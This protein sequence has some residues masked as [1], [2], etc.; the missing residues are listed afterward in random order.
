MCAAV[1]VFFLRPTVSAQENNQQQ[2]IELTT[3]TLKPGTAVEFEGHAKKIIAAFKKEGNPDGRGFAG[4]QVVKGGTGGVYLFAS[5]FT[6]WAE[7]DVEDRFLPT[8]NKVYGEKEARKIMEGFTSTIAQTKN[9]MYRRMG[10]L[11]TTTIGQPLKA[12]AIIFARTVKTPMMGEYRRGMAKVKEANEKVGGAAPVTHMVSVVGTAQTI[13]T[14]I[15]F[16]KY[17]EIDTWGGRRAL[18]THYGDAEA[19]HIREQMQNAVV[20]GTSYSYILA[21]RSDLSS[22]P[23]AGNMANSEE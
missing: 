13:I 11:S 21:F 14:G 1:C 4:F 9:E 7:L 19:R 18:V 20:E 8:M 2:F 15:G 22:M 10:N 12:F 17:A 5:P 16:D 6:K 3:I 23:D